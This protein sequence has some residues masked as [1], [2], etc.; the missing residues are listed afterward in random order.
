[1]G[2][3]YRASHTDTNGAVERKAVRR[4]PA[5]APMAVQGFVRDARLGAQG[6][7]SAL[8]PVSEPVGALARV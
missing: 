3:A 6:G 4:K 8:R 7:A 5:D 2:V 1:M